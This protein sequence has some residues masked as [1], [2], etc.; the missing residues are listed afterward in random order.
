M[1]IC[2]FVDPTLGVK[3]LFE[4]EGKVEKCGIGFEIKD[5]HLSY[6]K[7]R[8][9]EKFNTELACLFTCNFIPWLSDSFDSLVNHEKDT[10]AF[11]DSAKGSSG[12]YLCGQINSFWKAFAR[13]DW[14]RRR[15][16][17]QFIHIYAYNRDEKF[18]DFQKF[19]TNQCHFQIFSFG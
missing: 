15:M 3:K 7:R 5:C 8:G 9:W 14:G 11:V 1:F 13:R 2:L 19:C 17:I 10:T 12:N 6:N 4:K 18:W 16:F